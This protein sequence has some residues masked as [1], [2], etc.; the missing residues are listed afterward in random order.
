MGLFSNKQLK[1]K[2]ILT[3]NLTTRIDIT[4]KKWKEVYASIMLKGLLLNFV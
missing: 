1:N 3:I 4:G 2:N